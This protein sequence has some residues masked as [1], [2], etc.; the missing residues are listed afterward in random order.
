MIINH[1][2]VG[3]KSARMWT[4]KLFIEQFSQRIDGLLC[5]V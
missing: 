5:V 3:N 2:E 1:R 4:V